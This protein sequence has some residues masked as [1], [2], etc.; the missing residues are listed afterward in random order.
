M[1]LGDTIMKQKYDAA[2]TPD[3]LLEFVATLLK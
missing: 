3:S 2:Y 1:Q